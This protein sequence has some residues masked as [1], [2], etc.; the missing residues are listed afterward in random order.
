MKIP[1]ITTVML[2]MALIILP[3]IS[4]SH[5]GGLDSYGCHHNRTADNHSR[6]RPTDLPLTA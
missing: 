4:Q 5:G 1:F 6:K 3:G 2:A